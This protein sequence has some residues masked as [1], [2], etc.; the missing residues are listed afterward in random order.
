MIRKT[1]LCIVGL[2]A[3]SAMLRA[4]SAVAQLTGQVLD[5]T[6]AVIVGADVTVT[7]E[8]TGIRLETKSN[9]DGYYSFPL[10][11]PGEYRLTVQSQGFRPLTRSGLVLRVNQSARIDLKLEL[12]QTA[13]G[14]TV[15]APP[16][17]V[18]AENVSVGAVIDSK[19]IVELPLNGR[20]FMD[21]ALLTPGVAR[22]G[23]AQGSWALTIA[24][25]RPQNN[26]FLLDG[27]QNTDG[28]YNKAV[29]S[30]SIDLIQEFKVQTSSYSAEFGRA[31][32][33]QINVITRSGGNDFH[34]SVYEFFRN[35]AMDA[36]Q[37]TSPSRLPY[38]NRHQFGFAAG[39][40]VIR[41]RTFFFVNYEGLRRV[42]GQSAISSVPTNAIRNGDFSGLAPIYDP[43]SSQPNPAFNPSLPISSTNSQVIRQP[44][45]NNMIP[46]SRINGITSQVLSTVPSP[47][48]PGQ[49]SNYL[50]TRGA[51]ESDN[52]Y[53]IRGDHQFSSKNNMF[54]RFS[55]NRNSSYSPGSFPGFGTNYIA[56]PWNLTISDVHTFTPSLLN[57]FK[58]GVAR[59]YESDLQ[60]NAYGKDWIGQL[61]I[62]GV[63]FGGDAARGLPQFSVQNYTAFGDGTFAL[64]RLLRNTTLQWLDNLT[65]IKGRHT[66]KFGF[67]ARRFRYNLQA[68]Y[69]SRGY[70]QF[71]NGFTTGTATADG[72]G[73]SMASYLLGLPTFSQ[74]Q[75]GQTLIDP[76]STSLA[77]Y[78]QDDIKLSSRLTLN[79]GVRYE[80]TTPLADTQGRLPNADLGTLTNGMPTIYIGGQL[81]YPKGLV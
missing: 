28:D 43:D 54:A 77:G 29:V 71:T 60:E 73:H 15:E 40:P 66:A 45:A 26:N 22:A 37:F 8:A 75:V 70:F 13:E 24:G 9:G 69:Q 46:S 2:L 35:S 56:N 67:E 34:G 19:K 42:Q 63:G 76:R 30:P 23:G 21:L 36:R 52:Q 49:V 1:V 78:A 51:R 44:F 58:F 5:P 50:D 79:L 59:V 72:T 27:T 57:E 55:S 39:G 7:N 12:G 33:G 6:D 17:M 47:N 53:S 48:L 32:A 20:S 31:G 61:G 10:L 3:T 14:I 68:W 18:N 4:Q 81:G 11:Q 16:P 64:P 62:P 74:R 65:W 25:G 41:N 80:M 38:F